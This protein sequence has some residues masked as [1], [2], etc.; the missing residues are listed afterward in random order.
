MA[1][2]DPFRK[3][4]AR[5]PADP[6]SISSFL[7]LSVGQADSGIHAERS[8]SR[9]WCIFL[10]QKTS[11]EKT[12]ATKLSAKGFSGM[13]EMA[14]LNVFVG[15][16]VACGSLILVAALAVEHWKLRRVRLIRN[17]VDELEHLFTL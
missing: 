14:G 11:E 4:V 12:E 16:L 1:S 5:H 7:L 6:S 17:Q 13:F 3:N 10:N 8:V 9:P 2:N 15:F